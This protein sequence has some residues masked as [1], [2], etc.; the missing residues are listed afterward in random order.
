MRHAAGDRRGNKGPRHIGFRLCQLR[1]GSL[2]LCFQYWNL[3]FDCHGI[4]LC[5]GKRG[6]ALQEV[7]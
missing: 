1:V 2:T 5:S 7:G 6:F 4:G 3:F